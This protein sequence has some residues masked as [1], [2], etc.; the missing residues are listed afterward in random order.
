MDLFNERASSLTKLKRGLL[1]QILPTRCAPL[2]R[3]DF[4]LAA[5]AGRAAIDV[6]LSH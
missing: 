4:F 1:W 6:Q 5:D 3:Q 2:L